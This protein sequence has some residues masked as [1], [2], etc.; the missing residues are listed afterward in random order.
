M[1]WR[2]G[3]RR[4][5]PVNRGRLLILGNWSFL[6]YAQGFLLPYYDIRRLYELK[7]DILRYLRSSVTTDRWMHQRWGGMLRGRGLQYVK[8]SILTVDVIL[9]S[10]IL[11]KHI[12][13]WSYPFFVI[14]AQRI[15]NIKNRLWI[16]FPHRLTE[17]P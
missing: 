4:I 9:K 8:H 11:S 14:W 1:L 6:W 15:L 2:H 17:W 12:K 5:L 3:C 10:S 16:I 7:L 13:H